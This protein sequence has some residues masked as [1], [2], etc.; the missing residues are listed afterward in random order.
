[1]GGDGM[2]LVGGWGGQRRADDGAR[3]RRYLCRYTR[4]RRMSKRSETRDP[5]RSCKGRNE[6]SSSLAEE[7]VDPIVR[8]LCHKLVEKRGNRLR[9][10]MIQHPSQDSQRRRKKRKEKRQ[11]TLFEAFFFADEAELEEGRYVWEMPC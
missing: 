7:K 5:E 2:R 3:R 10:G 11:R 1:M 9:H 4:G 6:P 8:R